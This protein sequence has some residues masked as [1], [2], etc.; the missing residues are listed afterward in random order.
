MGWFDRFSPAQRQALMIGVPAVAGFVI[1]TRLRR[2]AATGATG[3]VAMPSTDA[4]GVGQLQDFEKSIADQMAA[5]VDQIAKA[6]AGPPPTPPPA[7]APAPAPDANQ[8]N[9]NSNSAPPPPVDTP[10]PA[11]SADLV[12]TMQAGGEEL[13]S[14]QRS[15]AGGWLY[16]TSKGGI[17][18][19]GGS[20]FFG[21]YIGYAS[22]QENPALES[23]LHGHFGAGGLVVLPGGHYELVNTG[24]ETYNF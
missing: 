18:N 9:M 21:S 12:A 22:T 5:L 17:Y 15:S 10:A 8:A 1:V 7:P 20:P 2:P 19:M 14:V 16:L 11:L 4:I 6:T 3:P 23:Q 13:V 24:G